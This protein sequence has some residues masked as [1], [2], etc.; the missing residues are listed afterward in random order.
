MSY[1]DDHE[2]GHRDPIIITSPARFA[3][4]LAILIITVGVGAAILI[5]FFNDM[6]KNPPP[7][8]RAQLSP[9][10]GTPSGGNNT[11]GGTGGGTAQAGVVLITIPAGAQTQ[12]NKAYDPDPAQVP[13]GSKVQFK[14]ADSV[15]HTATSGTGLDDPNKGKIFDTQYTLEQGKTSDPMALTGAKAGDTIPYFCQVHPFMKGTIKVTAAQAGGA[16]SG[17]A[18]TASGPTLKIPAGAQTQGNP[19]FDPNP[20]IAKKGD[21]V[22]ITNTD[23]VPHTVTSGTATDDPNSGKA[24]DTSIIEAG[25]TVT[26]TLDKVNAGDN[27]FYCMVHP[28]MKG[29]I[30]V[31]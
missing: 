25:K 19:S 21:T 16:S 28:F 23:T 26:I 4:G 5:P 30:K 27:P 22:T 15:L 24:F 14:N 29:V 20:L 6:N 9:G 2:Q 18:P 13:E 17:G 31:S 8:S 12:G 1:D 10:G 3:K 11:G 7:V